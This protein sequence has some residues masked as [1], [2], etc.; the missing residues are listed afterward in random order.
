MPSRVP[1]WSLSVGV[2]RAPWPAAPWFAGTPAT[3]RLRRHDGIAGLLDHYHGAGLHDPPNRPR[4]HHLVAER[5]GSI[6]PGSPETYDESGAPLGE[7]TA[8]TLAPWRVAMSSTIE[9]L[10]PA[11]GGLGGFGRSVKRS[12]TWAGRLAMHWSLSRTAR[13]RMVDKLDGGRLRART[14]PRCRQFVYE[15]G[16][17]PDL[18]DLGGGRRFDLLRGGRSGAFPV[19]RPARPNSA[20]RIVD[21]FAA[22]PGRSAMS[23]SSLARAVHSRSSESSRRQLVAWGPLSSGCWRRV[24]TLV[25]K[26]VRGV[27]LMSGVLYESLL[28]GAGPPEGVRAPAKRRPAADLVGARLGPGVAS[29]RRRYRSVTSSTPDRPPSAG[30]GPAG[31]AASTVMTPTRVR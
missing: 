5:A 26:L 15:A 20:S 17:L 4:H 29:R 27:Q 6:R 10:C 1:R 7:F 12:N 24:S 8:L 9:R 23:T 2:P 21:G 16:D 31:A 30:Y 18:T 13:Y 28:L 22:A 3:T 11:P 19:R 14:W 25:R